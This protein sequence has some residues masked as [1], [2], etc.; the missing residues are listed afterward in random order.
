MDI[1]DFNARWLAAWSAKDTAALL[2]FYSASATYKDAQVPAG[3]AGHPALKAY[4]DALFAAT[5]PMEYV[6]DQVW[7][8]E[9][10]YCGRWNCAMELPGGTKQSLR[11]FDLV[12]LEG[13]QIVYNEVYTHTV[14]G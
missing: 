7:A 12:L 6:P 3:I 5:P 4:L 9:G 2:R 8:I 13:D 1:A 10:G 14:P 11:G